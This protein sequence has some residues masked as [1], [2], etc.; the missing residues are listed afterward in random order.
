MNALL[1]QSG[2]NVATA[3]LGLFQLCIYRQL[4]SLFLN[5]SVV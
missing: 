4:K 3:R 1:T 5:V 2:K